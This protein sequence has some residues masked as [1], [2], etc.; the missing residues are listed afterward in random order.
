MARDPRRQIKIAHFDKGVGPISVEDLMGMRQEVWGDLRSRITAKR[1]HNDPD[2]YDARC[3]LCDQ[4]VFIRAVRSRTSTLPCYAHFGGMDSWCAWSSETPVTPDQARAMQYQGRQ[5]SPTHD[6]LCSTLSEL[7]SLDPRCVDVQVEKYLAPSA[8]KH[9]RFPDVYVDWGEI[10]FVLELQ[11]SRTFQTEIV[12]RSFHYDSE[13]IPLIWVLYGI[14]IES[15]TLPQSFIDVIRE[16]RENAFVIDAESCEASR[17][18]KTLVLKC[19][20]R[21]G[22]GFTPGRLVTID[23]L[24]FPS[25]GLPYLSDR[26]TPA[27]LQSCKAKREQI[28]RRMMNEPV[29]GMLE[30]EQGSVIDLIPREMR[31]A[32]PLKQ[33]K[34]L[35]VIFGAISHA[36]GKPRGF[37]GKNANLSWTIN[38]FYNDESCW[39]A[40]QMIERALIATGQK[41]RLT[42]KCQ[43]RHAKAL[44][45]DGLA[46]NSPEEEMLKHFVA[47]IFDPLTVNFLQHYAALPFW[48]ASYSDNTTQL[49]Q[50]G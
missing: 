40:A 50:S 32:T 38:Q 45:S 8:S 25:K 15:G 33:L 19:F 11:L 29:A 37:Y 22:E 30:Q 49:S 47:E 17:E 46:E 9:G 23:S 16:H 36:T 4:P 20:E 43:E 44:T 39:P 10:K 35:A 42:S 6:R 24:T 34:L 3:M 2:G 48:C 27:T 26:I 14:D 28:L 7:A 31:T 13:K 41:E 12:N 1:Q 21:A 5:V 18:Q